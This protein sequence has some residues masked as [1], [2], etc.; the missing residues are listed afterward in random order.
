MSSRRRY[1]ELDGKTFLICVGAMK[2]ATSWLYA[3]L[4]ASPEV[5]VSPLKEVHF[6][7]ARFPEGALMDTDLLAMHRLSFHISQPGDAAE[8]LRRRPAF[9]ASVDRVRMIFDDNAYFEH[10]ARFSR[11]DTRVL[12]DITPAY[13]VIGSSGFEFMRRCCASQEMSLKILFILR[14]PVDR[15]WS[16]LRFIPQLDPKVDPSRD[17]PD[18]LRDPV[19]MARSDYRRT[20]GDLESVFPADEIIYLFYEDLFSAGI[21][22]LCRTLGVREPDVDAT[23]RFNQTKLQIDLADETAQALRTALDAQYAFCR[24]RFGDELPAAWRVP[25]G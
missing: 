14:D 20:M 23:R 11:P 2:A 13:A 17:W 19:T 10:F 16:H 6:F 22:R 7:D 9:Q 15:L 21:A 18:L 4:R 1:R 5:S 8:N 3:Q 12:A 25:D 24:D